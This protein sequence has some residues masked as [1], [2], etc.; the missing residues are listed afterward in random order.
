[1]ISRFS[2]ALLLSCALMAG[3]GQH[4][5][6]GEN[7]SWSNSLKNYGKS[8]CVSIPGAASLYCFYKALTLPTP[9]QAQ[10][11]FCEA[12]IENRISEQ[13]QGII[14]R[15][16]NIGLSRYIDNQTIENF[17]PMIQQNFPRKYALLGSGALLVTAGL[18]YYLYKPTNKE[19]K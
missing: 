10:E 14:D 1:M 2:K 18:F 5:Q 8:L 15:L 3:V 17:K 7:E 12:F 16:I 13:R 6:A 11:M 19:N 4:V 9:E